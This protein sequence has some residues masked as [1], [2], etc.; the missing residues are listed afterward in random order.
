MVEGKTVLAPPI[1]AKL[2]GAS[3]STESAFLAELTERER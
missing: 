3:S 2:A 1:V